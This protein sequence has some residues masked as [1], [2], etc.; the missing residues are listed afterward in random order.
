MQ[1]A[2]SVCMIELKFERVKSNE[3]DHAEKL[4]K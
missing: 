1:T 2:S 4:P 3:F